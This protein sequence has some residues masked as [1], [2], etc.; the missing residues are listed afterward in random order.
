MVRQQLIRVN[1]L[2]KV[3][4]YAVSMCRFSTNGSLG[5]SILAPAA[6]VATG[7]GLAAAPPGLIHTS[8]RVVELEH[9]FSDLVRDKQKRIEETILEVHRKQRNVGLA[10]TVLLRL[11][12]VCRVTLG[13]AD[14]EHQ[15]P[16]KSDTRFGVA[17]VTKAF[18]G[19]ALLKVWEAKKI[20]LD[21]PIQ[22]YVPSFP[23]K[24]DGI[25][26]PRLVAA[27]LAGIR[28][29]GNERTPG[30]YATHFN[31]VNDVLRLFQNDPL[32]ARPGTKYNY[33]SCGYN[34]LGATIQSAAHMPFPRYIEETIIRPL[35]LKNT[36]FDD[37]RRVIPNR[38]RRYSFYDPM[39]FA[40]SSDVLRVPDWDYSHNLAGGNMLATADDLAHFGEALLRPGLLSKASVELLYRRTKNDYVES[41]VSFGWFVGGTK[42]ARREI[43]IT[44]SNAGVQAAV[45]VYPDSELV[46]AVLSN[47]W[48]VGSRSGEMVNA[49]PERIASI[50]LDSAP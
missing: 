40:E 25:I 24:P 20:E 13:Y 37:V 41:P 45:Y 7:V 31:D 39:T 5:L 3:P 49:L 42:A 21:A 35:G 34:L 12:P 18:T 19:V 43:H 1:S 2:D 6:L 38:S 8:P 14:L 48:G 15:V 9:T 11:Q 26:T 33:S 16:V 36:Q 30:L 46:V 29:W 44:G 28:H 23:E 22:R 32:I 47:T 50:C 4:E 10:A 17:S 27:H